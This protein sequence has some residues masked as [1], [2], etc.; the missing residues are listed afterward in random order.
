MGA[1]S[2]VRSELAATRMGLVPRLP[3]DV[4]AAAVYNSLDPSA[5]SNGDKLQIKM[6]LKGSNVLVVSI[7]CPLFV[8][9]RAR[10]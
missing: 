2:E 4:V 8:V 1:Q 3:G 9:F 7:Y 10:R 5:R 6:S